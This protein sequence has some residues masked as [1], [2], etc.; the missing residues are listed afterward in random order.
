MAA[1]EERSARAESL[2]MAASHVGNSAVWQDAAGLLRLAVATDGGRVEPLQALCQVLLEASARGGRFSER[3]HPLEEVEWLCMDA[4]LLPSVRERLTPLASRAS[5]MVRQETEWREA[6][7]AFTPWPGAR[8]DVMVD[9][10]SYFPRIVF[11]CDETSSAEVSLDFPP[12][13]AQHALGTE[14][15]TL[16]RH[17][18]DDAPALA[19]VTARGSPSVIVLA[20]EGEYRLV[21][22][23][24][25]RGWVRYGLVTE[26]RRFQAEVKPRGSVE[27]R[28]RPCTAELRI[29][30]NGA[31]V[32]RGEVALKP[33][34]VYRWSL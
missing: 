4:R 16:L 17:P 3:V 2:V 24:G 20:E 31:N 18:R 9:T 26:K 10:T 33:Y 15:A 23:G 25:L 8:Y 13:A 21:C 12:Q 6:A 11:H 14:R 19:T 27:L 28:A 5:G 29:D 34:L 7:E 1:W 30:V 22:V 32:F